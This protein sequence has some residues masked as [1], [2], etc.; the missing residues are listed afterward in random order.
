MERQ[1]KRSRSEAWWRCLEEFVAN[2]ARGKTFVCVHDASLVA[3]CVVT[4]HGPAGTY[5]W[6][7]SVEDRLPFTKAVLPLVAAVR[8]AKD[9]GCEVFDMGGIPLLLDADPKRNAIAILKRDFG[10]TPTA[11]TREHARWLAW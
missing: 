1:G 9:A 3:A 7:A 10:G 4:R 11:L 2:D 8:W 5:A 6:G